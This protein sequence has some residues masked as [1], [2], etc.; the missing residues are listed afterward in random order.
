LSYLAEYPVFQIENTN[1]TDGVDLRGDA[2]T[3]VSFSLSAPIGVLGTS[4]QGVGAGLTS[5]GNFTLASGFWGSVLAD[6]I[7]LYLPLILKNH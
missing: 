3:R 7:K 6:A 5:G 2:G 1:T 4:S